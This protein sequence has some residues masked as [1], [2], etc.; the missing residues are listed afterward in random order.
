MTDFQVRDITHILDAVTRVDI[1]DQNG[2]HE[3]WGDRWELHLQDDNRTLKL[4]QRDGYGASTKAIRHVSLARDLAKG[5]PWADQIHDAT[6][7][8]EY[9][10]DT[11]HN[12]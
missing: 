9:H 6:G 1:V 8:D 3:H 11:T 2:T 7:M 10:P 5:P 12:P 4:V